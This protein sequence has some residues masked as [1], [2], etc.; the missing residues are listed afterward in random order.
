LHIAEICP[1]RVMPVVVL[2]NAD[3]SSALRDALQRGGL[4]CAEVTLRTPAAEL[5]IAELAMDP[6]FVV[7]AGTVL[8]PDQVHRVAEAGARFVVSPGF[9]LA[10]AET[11]R[12][13]GLAYFPGVAT[14]TEISTALMYGL[15]ELKFFPAEVLGGV[16]ALKALAAPFS[17]VSF[18]PTGGLN[19]DNAADYLALPSVAA[20]GGSWIATDRLVATGDFT[21]IARR[22]ARAVGLSACAPAGVAGG[23]G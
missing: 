11:C 8:R 2:T 17:D 16:A 6:A 10:V 19:E 21:E 4:H 3:A 22:S 18:M 12:Q 1:Q 5:A 15:R 7:G 23:A 20:V 14:P 13:F 9:S